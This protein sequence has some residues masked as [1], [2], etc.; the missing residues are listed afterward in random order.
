MAKRKGTS[1]ESMRGYFRDQFERH[2]E[3]LELTN[4]SEVLDQW[5][6]DH[7]AQEVP[8][9]VRQSMSSI[10]SRMRSERGMGRMRRKRRKKRGAQAVASTPIKSIVKDVEKLELMIDECLSIARS[11]ESRKL[12]PVIKHLR[13]ARAHIVLMFDEEE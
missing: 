12:K 4:N 7:N 1:D 3:W 5:K 6:R 13:L 9:N 8:A 10:K 11:L 2:P